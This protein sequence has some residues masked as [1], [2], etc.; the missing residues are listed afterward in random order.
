MGG[1][2]KNKRLILLVVVL[3]GLIWLFAGRQNEDV[4]LSSPAAGGSHL[5]RITRIE[6]VP[7]TP[8]LQSVLTVQLQSED[9]T[10]GRETYRYKW[11]INKK[12]VGDQPV[13]S[14]AGFRQG[15]LVSVQVIPSNG[16]ADGVPVQSSPVKIGNN[17]PGVTV[18][19]LVPDALKAGQAVRAEVE[20]SDKDGDSI[21]YDYE[22]YINDQIIDGNNGAD[23]D[24][25]SIHSSDKVFVKVTP[26][27]SYSQGA[28]KFS[29]MI[30]VTNQP[31]EITSLPPTEM[32]EGKYIY[33]IIAK[34][35]DGDP[36]NFQLVEAPPEMSVNPSSGLLEWNV[37]AP[38]SEN[39]NVKV[40]VDDA[41]GGKTIQQ[42]AIRA[43]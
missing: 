14:L 32:E 22:W 23:L 1:L 33:Q 26:S 38:P 2:M 19:K 8:D 27:D 35:P 6:I 17:P 21:R 28:P 31:P 41:K 11:F 29:R 36:L 39:V 4:I 18:V 42:F 12:E 9:P 16:N 40:Q 25:K 43:G 24:G 30:V 5:P 20:G 3:V 10:P 37:K 15:D 7:A 13:L 34:D